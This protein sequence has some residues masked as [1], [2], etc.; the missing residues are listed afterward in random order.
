MTV[1]RALFA[2]FFLL[3]CWA[4]AEYRVFTLH[5]ENTADLSVRQLDTTLDPDQYKSLY[6]LQQNERI[7]YT[8]TWRCRGRT[9]FFRGHC[10]NPALTAA[11]EPTTEPV[12]DRN[13]AG[14][15]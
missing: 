3:T 13:P 4:R 5:I 8:Q 2:L 15:P 1:R 9:D 14:L 6:P 7:T 11:P 10:D 12:L